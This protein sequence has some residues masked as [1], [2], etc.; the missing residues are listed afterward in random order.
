M[1]NQPEIFAGIVLL[2]FFKS[3][4]LDLLL[5]HV[6]VC[7]DEPACP[8]CQSTWLTMIASKIVIL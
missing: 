3:K 7:L 2:D 4:V 1:N 6:C 8:C 5:T